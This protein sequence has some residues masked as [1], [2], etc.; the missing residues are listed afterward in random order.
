VQFFL[1]FVYI[2]IAF[3]NPIIRRMR[4]WNTLTNI[5]PPHFCVCSKPGSGYLKQY[6]EVFFVFKDW[7]EMIV[8]VVDTCGIVD[9]HCLI[10]LFIPIIHVNV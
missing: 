2:R 4:I 5:A 6:L 1:S 3:E 8:P 10:F 9:H 7:G